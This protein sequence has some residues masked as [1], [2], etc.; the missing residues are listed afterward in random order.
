MATSNFFNENAS[1]I[2]ALQNETAEDFCEYA[3]GPQGWEHT[4]EWEHGMR[5]FA[6]HIFTETTKCFS[7][8]GL[9]CDITA[10]IGLRPGY[11]EGAN[12]DFRL[13]FDSEGIE[14]CNGDTETFAD[15]IM[16]YLDDY[17]DWYM[18]RRKYATGLFKMNRAK[19]RQALKKFLDEMCEEIN[20]YMAEACDDKLYAVAH[21][22]NGETWY[23]RAS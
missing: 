2:Y 16:D 11:Y 17:S 4:S 13:D 21:F 7:F 23:E 1:A 19:I 20:A 14:L 12:L 3:N 22:S 9:D 5:D 18:G 10:Q 6:M 8:S 15:D